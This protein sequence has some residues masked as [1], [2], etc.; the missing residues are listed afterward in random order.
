MATV[1][2]ENDECLLTQRQTVDGV[3]GTDDA[4]L[5]ANSAADHVLQLN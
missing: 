1:Q 3:Q 4:S 5:K 2:N